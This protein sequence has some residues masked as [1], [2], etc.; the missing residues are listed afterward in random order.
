[1][2]TIIAVGV[3]TLVVGAFGAAVYSNYKN[4]NDYYNNRK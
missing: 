4:Y 2:A 1:M 3:I